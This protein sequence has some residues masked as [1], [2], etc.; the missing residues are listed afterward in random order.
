MPSKVPPR[1]GNAYQGHRVA[2]WVVVTVAALLALGSVVFPIWRIAFNFPI[3]YN[4]GWNVYNAAK[5]FH[6]ILLYGQQHSLTP[7]IYPPLSFYIIAWLHRLGLSYL[8]SGRMV[9]LVSLLASCVLV[10]FIVWKLTR[11]HRAAIFASFFCLALFCTVATRYVGMDDPQMLAQ[12]FFL[13][14]LLIYIY[15]TPTLWRLAIVSLLFILGGNIK[16]DLVG[17][18]LAVL[19]D[20]C[21][22][23]RKKV[24]A[25]LLISSAFLGASIGLTMWLAGPF[26]VSNILLPRTFLIGKAIRHFALEAFGPVQVPLIIAAFWSL[27]AFRNTRLRIVVILFWSSMLFGF[28]FGGGAGVDLNSYFDLYLS[29]AIITGLFLHWFWESGH[30]QLGVMGKWDV[31]GKIGVPLA[32]LLALAPTWA[33]SGWVRRTDIGALRQEGAEFQTEVSFLRSRPGPAICESLLLCNEAGK[34]YELSPIDSF[35]LFKA[36]WLSESPVIGAMDKK[37]FGA[38]ELDHRTSWYYLPGSNRRFTPEFAA[39]VSSNY[40]LAFKEKGCYIYIPKS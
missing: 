30:M 26:F 21:F 25:Y 8:M 1:S 35:F 38:V 33:A 12:A 20:L 19:V 36:G 29:V 10:G 18:P 5:V 2:Q 13:V 32:L 3:D 4:E 22:V 28:I 7:V 31:A 6:H 15:G 16:H 17:F 11:E 9:S 23:S 24:A 39:A 27:W 37:E 34:R 14:G 40:E